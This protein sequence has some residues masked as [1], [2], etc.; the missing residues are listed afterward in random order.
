MTLSVTSTQSHQPNLFKRLTSPSQLWKSSFITTKSHSKLLNVSLNSTS[1]KINSWLSKSINFRILNS[2]L[3]KSTMF[4][5]VSSSSSIKPRITKWPS[6]PK[7]HRKIISL[8]LRKLLQ[9][10][11]S[12]L[13]ASIKRFF[14]LS[15]KFKRTITK[16]ASIGLC[17]LLTTDKKLR[18]FVRAAKIHWWIKTGI[19]A[20]KIFKNLASK[21]QRKDQRRKLNNA[22]WVQNNKLK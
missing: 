11:R 22:E 20:W 10:T 16:K 21:P 12:K 18:Y 17:F 13:P 9:S 3:N 8:R 2:G 15:F 1:R 19:N 4:F 5:K 14:F 7:E 6:K